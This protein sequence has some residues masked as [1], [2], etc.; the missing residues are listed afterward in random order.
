MSKTISIYGFEFEIGSPYAEGHT[1][2]ALEANALNQV[3]AENI[4]NNVRAKVK[5]VKD[6]SEGP[7]QSEALAKVREE[8]EK[9]AANYQFSVRTVG[10]GSVLSPEEKEA[11]K[12]ARAVLNSKLAEAGTTY[13]AYLDKNG[14]DYVDEKIIEISKLDQVVAAAKKAVKE[15][16]KRASELAGVEI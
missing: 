7:E 16:Q 1:L 5:A 11:R 2:T 12:L 3:R 4:G 10:A 9:I 8:V 13:K 14:K 6:M 15:A